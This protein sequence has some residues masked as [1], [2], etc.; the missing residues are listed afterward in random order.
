MRKK[1]SL[2]IGVILA[3]IFLLFVSSCKD[4]DE[5]RE[6]HH[7]TYYYQVDVPNADDVVYVVLD[8]VTTKIKSV[9]NY[10]DWVS[11]MVLD[12]MSNGH[13]IVCL[14]V[15]LSEIDENYRGTVLMTTENEDKVILILKLSLR[16]E[17]SDDT[18]S[19]DDFYTNWE[20]LESTCVLTKNGQDTVNLPWADQASTTIPRNIRI[21]V[22][23]ADGWEMAF[24]SLNKIGLRDCNYFMLYNRYL[25]ILRVFYYVSDASTTGSNY[26]FEVDLGSS[27][28]TSA[29]KSAFY[30]SLAYAIPTNHKV[31]SDADLLGGCKQ[32]NTFKSIYE[33]HTTASSPAL[34]IGWTAFDIDMTAYCSTSGNWKSANIDQMNVYCKTTEYKDLS[35]SGSLTANIDGKYSSAEQ[36]QTSSSSGIS[37]LLTQLGGKMSGSYF[38]KGI[39]SLERKTAVAPYVHFLASGCDVA[40]MILD[41]HLEHAVDSMPGKIKMNLTGK[42]N[43]AGYMAG[44]ASNSVPSLTIG[45]DLFDSDSHFGEGV[46]N[47]TADPVIYVVDDLILGDAKSINLVNK[48]GGIYSN[49][50]VEDYHLRMVSFLD[51]T[52]VKLAINTNIFNDVSNVSVT[53]DYGVYPDVEAGHTSDYVSLLGF[54]RPTVD[55][56]K[57][58]ETMSIYRSSNSS[59]KTKYMR[60]PHTDFMSELMGE[61][62][63][64]EDIKTETQGVCEVVKQNGADYYYYGRKMNPDGRAFIVSPQVYFPYSVTDTKSE[65]KNGQIPDFVVLVTVRFQS[66]GRTFIFA[67]RFIPKVV[68]ISSDKLKEKL[69]E[70]ENYAEACEDEEYVN[71]FTVGGKTVG[72]LHTDGAEGIQKTIDILK[73]VVNY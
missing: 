63:G 10:P 47:L 44:F 42:I 66:G 11:V 43:L 55:I 26:S 17:D 48:G 25:G 54:S 36:Q 57:S 45:S 21:D 34:S 33:P 38:V 15:T 58:S 69:E 31:R 67:Q 64:A 23:K 72:V 68:A 4:K 28:N 56:V 32:P 62:A 2:I 29:F 39:E 6:V 70:L 13:P 8:S 41:E 16:S 65:I 20:N 27:D 9:V 61:V 37:K 3:S 14:S 18:S 53:C 22:K 30:H 50:E 46:W 5:T 19:D 60:L 51:P 7:S 12:S 24:C 40:A 59:N 49:N 52:S 1:F 35:L 73:A 71:T